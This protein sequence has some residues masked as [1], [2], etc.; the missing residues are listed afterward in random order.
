MTNK[1]TKSVYS[2]G[3]GKPT[4]LDVQATVGISKHM[5][6]YTATDELHDLCHL[7]QAQEVLD[8]GCGIGVGPA[9]IAKKFGCRVMAVDLS[10]DMLKWAQQRAERESVSEIIEFRQADV[11]SLPFEDNRFDAVLVESVLAFVEDKRTAIDELLRVTKPGGYIGLNESYWT[12]MPE[13][14][15]EWDSL[16]IGPSIITEAEWRKIWEETP[17]T[18]REIQL[19]DLDASQEVSDRVGWVGW[20]YIL[21]AWG[22]LIRM[23]FT[24][25][26]SLKSIQ[27]QLD[28]PR[29]M[30]DLLGYALFVGRKQGD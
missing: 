9:Y 19:R 4:Y 25:R 26:G 15:G 17:F 2:S 18:W 12:E 8:V 5:G 30:W 27:G 13:S 29:E 1:E 16:S 6:G 3:E 22:R 10:E 28:A 20:R 23:L 7:D 21:P 14:M 24:R 11:R